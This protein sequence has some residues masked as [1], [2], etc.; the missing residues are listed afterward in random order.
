MRRTTSPPMPLLYTPHRLQSR[1]EVKRW[2]KL[3]AATGGA[4]RRR[5]PGADAGVAASSMAPAAPLTA[6]PCKDGMTNL[7]EQREFR[8]GETA[9]IEQKGLPLP[10]A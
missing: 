9:Y 10:V 6:N 2:A 7:L 1:K 3:D 8:E 4:M 5:E